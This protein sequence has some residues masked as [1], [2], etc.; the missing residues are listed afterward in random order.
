MAER[1]KIGAA[2]SPSASTVAP[3]ASTT[4]TAPLWRLSTSLPRVTSTRIGLGITGG[5]LLR[6]NRVVATFGNDPRSRFA[7]HA[8]PPQNASPAHAGRVR[9]AD[10]VARRPLCGCRSSWLARG[11]LGE[12]PHAAAG[13][14]R[15]R[16]ARA[17]VRG[18]GRRLEERVRGP[19]LGG[20]QA[21]ERDRLHA[22]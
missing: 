3:S 21:G 14:S 2:T 22:L 10:R 6:R 20:G 17:G 4:A 16:G 7:R 1:G 12:H 18:A 9:A 15:P 5:F 8:H 13:G 11:E 19:H